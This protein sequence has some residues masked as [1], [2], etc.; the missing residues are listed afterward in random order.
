M[1]HQ[2]CKLGQEHAL[3]FQVLSQRMYCVS[4]C[5]IHQQSYI[6]SEKSDLT[7]NFVVHIYQ[8]RTQGD[9]TF[10]PQSILDLI[11]MAENTKILI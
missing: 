4:L 3:T 7:I 5:S 9:V 8:Y 2:Y 10:A 1:S 6:F 11:H